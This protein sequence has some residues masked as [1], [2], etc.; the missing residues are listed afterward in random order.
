MM[1]DTKKV[2]DLIN[3]IQDGSATEEDLRSYIAWCNKFQQDPIPLQGFESTQQAMLDRLHHAIENTKP[4]PRPVIR[5]MIPYAA[6]I[7]LIAVAGLFTYLLTADRATTV[8]MGTIAPGGNQATLILTNGEE[9]ELDNARHGIIVEDGQITYDD[10]NRLAYTD[11]TASDS[12]YKIR[13]PRGGQYQV[14]LPDGTKVWLNSLSDL[15]YP[16]RFTD[17]TR[18]VVLNG[19]AFFEVARDEKHPFIVKTKEMDVQ[20]LGTSFNIMSYDDEP[21]ITTTVATGIVRVTRSGNTLLIP[22]NKQAVIN[23]QKDS[24]EMADASVEQ[25][26]AWKNGYFQFD[27]A[28]IYAIMRQL[29]RWYDIEVR[30]DGDI[31]DQEY[32]ILLARKEDGNQILEALEESGA[33]KFTREGKSIR[34]SKR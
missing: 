13:T 30:F 12:H 32:Y 9:I 15:E 22:A 5:K 20:V 8:Q 18:E 27:G 14:T 3:R 25:A 19:E 2:E 26:I 6:A 28:D 34:V 4:D 10:G 24:F 29:S 16:A 7:F 21:F 23:K 31:P 11:H 17:S 33:F 1:N